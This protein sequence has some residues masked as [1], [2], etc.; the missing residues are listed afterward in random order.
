MKP[1]VRAAPGTRA[2]RPAVSGPAEPVLNRP[3]R[4]RRQPPSRRIGS[5]HSSTEDPLLRENPALHF[6]IAQ[7]PKTSGPNPAP[8]FVLG[9]AVHQ[10]ANGS[11]I[12]RERTPAVRAAVHK[13]TAGHAFP[14]R[15]PGS[16]PAACAATPCLERR[17]RCERDS[18]RGAVV[19]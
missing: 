7:S 1:L 11:A 8:L 12:V 18:V 13:M 14:V 6:I 10:R 19:A 2:V 5:F 3:R 9:I 16:R 15:G 17:R 4:R